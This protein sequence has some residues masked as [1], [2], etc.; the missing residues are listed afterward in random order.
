MTT[1]ESPTVDNGVNVAALL[2][3]REALTDMPEPPSSRGGRRRHG[4]TAPTRGPPSSSSSASAPS[5]HTAE[6][7]TFET[8][9]PE[10][11]AATTAA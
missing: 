5:S 7:F 9:H 3:A 8:D 6:P 2:G 10:I 11:F 4:S 1:T